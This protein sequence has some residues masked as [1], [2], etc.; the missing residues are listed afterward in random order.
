MVGK[1][2][3]LQL[4]GL[5]WLSVIYDRFCGLGTTVS[6]CWLPKWQTTNLDS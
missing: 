3:D 5:L 6:G 4:D 1:E 2:A